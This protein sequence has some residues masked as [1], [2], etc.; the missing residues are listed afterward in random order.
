M[1]DALK[2]LQKVPDDTKLRRMFEVLDQDKDGIIDISNA[3]EVRF[4][5][6]ERSLNSLEKKILQII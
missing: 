2:R 6:N 1:L 3:L 5:K 4:K